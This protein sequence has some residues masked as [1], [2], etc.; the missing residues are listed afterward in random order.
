MTTQTT[1]PVKKDVCICCKTETDEP[2]YFAGM[3]FCPDCYK[4][5]KAEADH[6]FQAMMN[7]PH[8]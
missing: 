1:K 3:C 8:F 6:A 7:T 4:T 5:R 2:H